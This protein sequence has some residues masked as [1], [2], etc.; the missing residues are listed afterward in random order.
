MKLPHIITPACALLACAPLSHAAL[1]WTGAGDGISA[2]Q[3][4]NWLDDNGLV[5]SA[6]TIN[7]GTPISAATGGL[8]EISSGSGSPSNYSPAFTLATDSGDDLTVSGGKTLGGAG[9]IGGGAG[10]TLTVSNGA[11]LLTGAISA[12]TEFNFSNATVDL[13][14]SN[15]I[16]SANGAATMLISAGSSLITQFIANSGNTTNITVD[17]LSSL[18]ILGTGNGI[19]NAKVNLLTGATLTLASEA[20]LDEQIGQNDIFVNNTL[21]T[22]ANR[23]TLLTVTGGQAIAVP[24]PTTTSLLGLAG[25]TLILRRRKG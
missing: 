6:G 5:P 14:G 12:F 8:I 20:E 17:G 21:V 9:L 1:V 25:I 11:S 15:G 4:A 10:S 24:E 16:N 13:T 19:N 18:E 3:E 22:L 23:D 7:G 2:F